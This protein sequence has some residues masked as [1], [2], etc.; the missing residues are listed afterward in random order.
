M[1]AFLFLFII[2]FLLL[3]CGTRSVNRHAFPVVRYN[4]LSVI[5]Q[6]VWVTSWGFRCH[7]GLLCPKSI[8]SYPFQSLFTIENNCD[9]LSGTSD[10]HMVPFSGFLYHFI[11]FGAQVTIDSTAFFKRFAVSPLFTMVVCYLD[12]HRVWNPVFRIGTINNNATV[13]A[14][15]CFEIQIPVQSFHIRF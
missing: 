7:P 12:F 14:Y 9:M 3:H 8:C 1:K 15:V 6:K 4:L 13:C 10:T 11:L 5:Q 2:S